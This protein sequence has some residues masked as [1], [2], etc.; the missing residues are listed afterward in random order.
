VTGIL[1]EPQIVSITGQ[2]I[3][4]QNTIGDVL[5]QS[6]AST[7]R[8][9]VHRNAATAYLHIGAGTVAAGS[10]PLKLTPG[11][12]VTVPEDGLIEYDGT[13]FYKTIGAT[14]SIIV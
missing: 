7:G 6:N 9:A 3:A 4:Y 13:N 5:L 1:F 12:L 2:L 14:R 8:T 11:P 10:G